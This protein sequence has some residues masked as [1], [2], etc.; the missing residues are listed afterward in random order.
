VGI[1][2]AGGSA[3][4]R[5]KIGRHLGVVAA[6]IAA[7]IYL[8]FTEPVF[9]EWSNWQNIIRSQAVVLVLAIGATMVV[10]TAGIDLS[11]ASATA[12]ASMVLGVLV[13]SGTAW[14]LACVA[15]A[16]A[17]VGLG[18]VNGF[19]IG[20]VRISLLVVTL[21]TLAI[22]Q[23]IAL[24]TTNGQTLTLLGYG[25]FHTI[26][27]LVN[28][29]VGPIP[30]ILIVAAALYALAAGLLNLTTFGRALYA[31]G[32]NPEAAR[33]GGINVSVVLVATY[34]LA[35]LFAGLAGIVST[36]RL[37]AAGP[38]VDPNLLLMVLTAVLIGGTSF[39]GGEGGVFGT[40]LGVLFLGVIQ[41]GLQLRNVSAFWQGAI[42]GSILI[43]AV[44]SGVLRDARWLRNRFSLRR[45]PR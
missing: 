36:G 33:L 3:S 11:A 4:R 45:G 13:Q 25:N 38:Q 5:V 24:L 1:P 18:F 37:T 7:C 29:S 21:G 23:S 17:G 14:F 20:K 8:G 32:A 15:T 40:A 6:I 26:D 43:I 10:I 2:R 41:N 22:Y 9:F 19:L 42:S 35:G 34:T 12:V 39:T 27:R 31:V 16:A 30:T 28:G 44:G